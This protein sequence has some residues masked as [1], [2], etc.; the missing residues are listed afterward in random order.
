MDVDSSIVVLTVVGLGEKINLSHVGHIVLP[1]KL[2]G[3]SF[4]EGG[5][6]ALNNSVGKADHQVLVAS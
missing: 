2:V 6:V 4:V 1:L 5:D 3:S